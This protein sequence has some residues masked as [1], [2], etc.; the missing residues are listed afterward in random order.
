M[1]SEGGSRAVASNTGRSSWSNTRNNAGGRVG[2][3]R[4]RLR[5]M[6]A[7][8]G[9][10]LAAGSAS[11]AA[12][13]TPPPGASTSG[14]GGGGALNL[15]VGIQVGTLGFG[16]QVDKLIVSHIGVRAGFNYF[17]FGLSHTISDVDYSGH[18]RLQSVP[19]LADIYP[20]GS[21]HLTGGLVFDQTQLTG[22]AVPDPSGTITI[23]HVSYTQSQIG[24]LNAGIKYPSSDGYLGLG[25]GSPVKKSLLGGT[26]DIGVILARPRV[27]LNATNAS[28]TP[29][30]AANLAAQQAT[31]QHSVNKLSVYPVLSSGIMLHF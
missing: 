22:T 3:L 17:E 12:Q 11:L 6:L 29:G 21:F 16:V 31:T 20:F 19:L 28:T 8:A 18:L 9:L 26:F 4:H 13:P 23:N 14:T 5:L 25:F 7:H 30:L 27:S 24:I 2:A 15:G 10:C 1:Q